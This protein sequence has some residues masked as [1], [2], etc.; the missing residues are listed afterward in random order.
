MRDYKKE[1]EWQKEKYDQI[2]A[3]IDREL[4][5]KLRDKLK[6]EQKSIAGWITENA[7]KYIKR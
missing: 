2:R 3:N 4:G 6:K 1:H 5:N 7:K